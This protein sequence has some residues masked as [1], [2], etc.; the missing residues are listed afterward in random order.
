MVVVGALEAAVRD[1]LGAFDRQEYGGI[2]RLAM[3]DA[4]GVDEIA[5]R[6]L[7]DAD[8]VEAYFKQLEG[9]VDDVSSTLSDVREDDWGDVG[10]VTCWLEQDYTLDGEPRHVSAPSSFV[11]RRY[12]GEW[13]IALIHT[14]PLP[15][16]G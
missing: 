13:R 15:E 3:P 2:L 9:A 1:V 16:E 12:E 8:E 11:L 5:R 6:W 10:L 14:V 7:R 4:Q